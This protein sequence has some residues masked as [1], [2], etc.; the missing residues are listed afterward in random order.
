MHKEKRFD[1]IALTNFKHMSDHSFV[2]TI[3][4]HL[5]YERIVEAISNLDEKYREVL[6]YH[7]IQ[8]LTVSE[9]SNLLDRKRSTVKMQLVRGKKMLLSQVGTEGD[10]SDDNQ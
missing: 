3:A 4:T 6:F 9:I 2:E 7:Y 5:E 10:R 1:T 8:E